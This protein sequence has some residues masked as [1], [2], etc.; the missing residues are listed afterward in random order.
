ML[1]SKLKSPT[2]VRGDGGAEQSRQSGERLT[3]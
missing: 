3:E 1:V 2:K